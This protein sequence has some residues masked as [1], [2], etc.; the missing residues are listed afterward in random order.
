MSNTTAVATQQTQTGGGLEVKIAKPSIPRILVYGQG[1]IGK[2]TFGAMFPEPLFVC[3]EKGINSAE[4]AGTAYIEASTWEN[5]LQQL[6]KFKESK[7]KTLVIDTLDELVSG[8]FNKYIC[9]KFGKDNAAQGVELVDFAAINYGKGTVVAQQEIKS[10]LNKL[11]EL[12]S[13][14]KIILL[15]SHSQIKNFKNPTGEDYDTY[16]IKG[17]DKLNDIVKCWCDEVYFA[18][19][20]VNIDKDR[21]AKG[22]K[23]R[24]LETENNAAWFAKSR[25]GLQGMEMDAKQVL[26]IYRK[27]I[28]G[29]KK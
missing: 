17:N 24:W 5:F 14:G 4:L 3:T 28:M 16:N 18:N 19:F 10:M 29:V 23:T 2:T 1:G 25:F 15:L 11:D 20:V 22:G 21:K 7:Y 8:I 12:N 13:A 27:K 9:G 26:D 6:A